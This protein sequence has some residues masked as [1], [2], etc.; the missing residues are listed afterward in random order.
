MTA[1]IKRKSAKVLLQLVKKGKKALYQKSKK[2]GGWVEKK[3]HS[4]K[5][6]SRKRNRKPGG[7][8][9]TQE[10]LT[11]IKGQKKMDKKKGAEEV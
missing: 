4:K 11:E 3:D 7:I 1:G 10:V 8:C 6:K 5:Q 9:L 2:V